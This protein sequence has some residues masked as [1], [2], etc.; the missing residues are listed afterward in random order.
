VDAKTTGVP[1]SPSL[2]LTRD[3]NPLDKDKY[4]YSELIGSLLYM[5]VCT[6]PDIAQAVGALARYMSRPTEGH[7][8]AAK[9]V[10]RYIASTQGIGICYTRK[11]DESGLYG[12]CDSDF[13]G[14]TDTRR[15]TTGYAFML[16]GGIISWSSHLQP[17]VAASTTEAEYMSAASATKEAL[18]LRTLMNDLGKKIE[19]VKIF[20]DN[21]ATISLLKHPV[22]SARSKHI[23]VLHHFARER[24]A[25]KEIEFKYIRTDEMVADVMTKALA[26]NKFE[27]CR[28]QMGMA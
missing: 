6:R 24:V 4:H 9:H 7:W 25:R 3:G 1:M 17:T 20:C 18:W 27:K 8:L 2:K 21:Q 12:Y 10:L 16:G 23:D 22:S 15:S 26:E 11:K 28:G 5:T 19:T 13:A 14:D